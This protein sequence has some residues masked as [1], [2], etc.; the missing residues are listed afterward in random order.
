MRYRVQRY[1]TDKDVWLEHGDRTER[2][3]LADISASG[4]RLRHLDQLSDGA[5]VTI[6][7]LHLRVP[8]RVVWSDDEKTAVRFVVPLS[9][10][11]RDAL[12]GAKGGSMAGWGTS[13]QYQLREL[14]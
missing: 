9:T 8:A 3:Q 6:R 10:T 13:V 2:V 1:P 4:A 12:R 14:S 5:L 7:H 11:D